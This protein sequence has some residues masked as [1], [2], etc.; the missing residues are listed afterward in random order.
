M[1]LGAASGE[2]H[3]PFHSVTKQQSSRG[4]DFEGHVI[5]Y[6]TRLHFSHIHIFLQAPFL[7]IVLYSQLKWLRTISPLFFF[8]YV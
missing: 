1:T 3:D 5:E 2:R 8:S 4:N 7:T 6:L